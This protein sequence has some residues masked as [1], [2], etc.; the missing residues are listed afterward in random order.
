MSQ[1]IE[2]K[3]YY[4]SII[5]KCSKEPDPTTKLDE[6]EEQIKKIIDGTFP[7]EQEEYFIKEAFYSIINSLWKRNDF[8][9]K[10]C[11]RVNDFFK[12]SLDLICYKISEEDPNILSV[13]GRIFARP[14]HGFY[15]DYQT[16]TWECNLEDDY[17]SY[18]IK[19]FVKE[20]EK[21]ED[22]MKFH[23][24]KESMKK[25]S[26]LFLE[27]IEYFGQI[28]G[29]EKIIS[30]ILSE[31]YEISLK[32][33]DLLKPI[34]KISNQ[35]TEEFLQYLVPYL[36][37]IL[38][39]I[40]QLEFGKIRKLEKKSIMKIADLIF[41]TIRSYDNDLQSQIQEEFKLD[42]AEKFIHSTY[43]EMRVAG[44]TEIRGFILNLN[45]SPNKK[46]I[47]QIWI[48]K[49]KLLHWIK[50][51]KIVELIFGNHLHRETINRTDF[52][53]EFLA[54]NGEFT[55]EIFYLIWNASN[56][57]HQTTIEAIYNL[58]SRLSQYFPE[59]MYNFVFNKFIN[60]EKW[61][62]VS[63]SLLQNFAR[64]ALE[65]YNLEES[66]NKQIWIEPIKKFWG[67]ITD[68]KIEYQTK[69][70]LFED[71]KEL[72][73]QKICANEIKHSFL[74]QCITIITY[75]A[76][77]SSDNITISALIRSIQ[78]ENN[79]IQLVIEEMENFKNK[80]SKI[81]NETED[82]DNFIVEEGLIY[83]EE[84]SVRLEFLKFIIENTFQ[85][86]FSEKQ[87]N[88]LWDLFFKNSLS[89]KEKDY[90]LD[91]TTR[92][93][94]NDEMRQAFFQ[95]SELFSPENLTNKEFDFFKYFS[96]QYNYQKQTIKGINVIKVKTTE[97]DGVYGIKTIWNIILKTTNEDVATSAIYYLVEYQNLTKKLAATY[98]A[99]HRENFISHCMK[100]LQEDEVK[101]NSTKILRVLKV[102]VQ[103]IHLTESDIIPEFLPFTRHMFGIH[104][105]ATTLNISIKNDEKTKYQVQVSSNES[106]FSLRKKISKLLNK[107]FADFSIVSHPAINKL[108]NAKTLLEMGVLTNTNLE[109]VLREAPKPKDNVQ[110]DGQKFEDD[111]FVD[112]N[113]P[114]MSDSK[115]AKK[116]L[117]H[118]DQQDQYGYEDEDQEEAMK[119]RKEFIPTY[120]LSQYFE[121]LFKLLE[122]GNQIAQKVWYIILRMPTNK[123]YLESFLQM[124][125]S[126]NKEMKWNQIFHI[127][128]VYKLIY[129]L[130][131]VDRL[132]NPMSFE[133]KEGN[134]DGKQTQEAQKIQNWSENFIQTGGLKYLIESIPDVSLNKNATDKSSISQATSL[135]LKVI[136]E[137]IVD[138]Q[139]ITIKF[140]KDLEN[141]DVEKFLNVLFDLALNFSVSP[142]TNHFDS[143]HIVFYAINIICSGC[144]SQKRDEWVAAIRNR[145]NMLD[146][147][148]ATLLRTYNDNI[149]GNISFGIYH[150]CKLDCD[151]IKKEQ[152]EIQT[153]PIVKFFIDLLLKLL[154]QKP[155]E[156]QQEKTESSTSQKV[157]LTNS[158]FQLLS[159]LI[160]MNYSIRQE[161]NYDELIEKVVHLLQNYISSEQS[162]ETSSQPDEIL[163]GYLNLARVLLNKEKYRVQMEEKHN[164]IK[165]IF[166]KFLF[167]VPKPS[168]TKKK[169]RLSSK[170]QTDYSRKASFDLLNQI[171]KD[172]PDNFIRLFH[173]LK[174]LHKNVSS[175]STWSYETISSPKSP[176]GYLGLTNL[177]ATCYM[178]SLLQ[179]LYM[180]PEFRK[181]ML[182][183]NLEEYIENEEMKKRNKDEDKENKDG[184]ENE[185]ENENENKNKN[186]ENKDE[187]NK[188]NKDIEDIK[189]IVKKTLEENP[190]YHL[191]LIFARLS[192][193]DRQ[194]VNT[195]PFTKVFKQ[196]DGSPLNPYVQMDVYEFYNMLFDVM[197][198]NLRSVGKGTL[199]QQLFGGKF[200]NQIIAIESGNVSERLENFY[201]ISLDVLNQRNLEESLDL[202][203][204]G[205]MLVGDNQY[206]SEA[207]QKKVDAL[208]RV[209][210][211]ELPKVMVVNLKRFEYDLETMQ[212][213]KI[214][215]RF[216][217]PMTLNMRKYTREGIADDELA[218]LLKKKETEE[219]NE[220]EL[221]EKIET[222]QKII[223][224]AANKVYGYHLSGIIVH[225]GS[226][227]SGHYY[228]FIK[229][230]ESLSEDNSLRWLKF[231]DRN[232]SSFDI[233]KIDEECFG[234]DY[235]YHTKDSFGNQIERLYEKRHS[236]YMLFYER[237]DFAHQNPLENE[238]MLFQKSNIYDLVWKENV[239]HFYQKSL[240]DP[241]YFHFLS[242]LIQNQSAYSNKQVTLE[243]TQFVLQFIFQILLYSKSQHDTTEWL[244]FLNKQ[245]TEN[246]EISGYLLTE[247]SKKSNSWLKEMIWNAY[248]DAFVKGL[249]SIILTSIRKILPREK[250]EIESVI[251]IQEKFA[252]Q[253][254]ETADSEAVAKIW[255]EKKNQ[256]NYKK[257]PVIISFVDRFVSLLPLFNHK[258]MNITEYLVILKDIIDLDPCISKYLLSA[259]LITRLIDFYLGPES[260]LST[261]S[262]KSKFKTYSLSAQM[263][264]LIELISA[265]LL[266]SGS[267]ENVSFMDKFMLKKSSFFSI[268][269]NN[270]SNPVALGDIVN[271]LYSTEN[272]KNEICE[273]FDIIT[274]G[275][276]SSEFNL[277]SK[278][279]VLLGKIFEK[280]DEFLQF[281]LDYLMPN[282]FSVIENNFKFKKATAASI[283]LLH[284][285]SSKN[286][287]MIDWL[288]IH[289]DEWMYMWLVNH[290]KV[291]S[292]LHEL[293]EFLLSKIPDIIQTTYSTIQPSAKPKQNSI[294]PFDNDFFNLTGY[295]NLM[296]IC[297]RNTPLMNKSFQTHFQELWNLFS[298]IESY[299][300]F[301][302]LNK[303]QFLKFLEKCVIGNKD[304]IALIV[305]SA[306]YSQQIIESSIT[307][308]DDPI[309]VEYNQMMLPSLFNIIL[310]SC[311]SDPEFLAN[312][313]KSFQFKWA[314]KFLVFQ[315]DL[316]SKASDFI[317]Q[318][319]ALFADDSHV[320]KTYLNFVTQNP[321]CFIKSPK[322]VIMLVKIILNKE[323]GILHIL[324][325][326][327]N[328]K[329]LINI[330]SKFII[331]KIELISEY[332]LDYADL[333][334]PLQMIQT[335][336]EIIRDFLEEI[337]NQQERR[338]ELVAHLSEIWTK[339]SKLMK[340]L[341]PAIRFSESLE[342]KK[343]TRTCL[344]LMTRVFQMDSDEPSEV[345]S[346]VDGD[347]EKNEMPNFVT[348][349]EYDEFIQALITSGIK[350][351]IGLAVIDTFKIILSLIKQTISK[352]PN[353]HLKFVSI[354]FDVVSNPKLFE[355][356]NVQKVGDILLNKMEDYLALVFQNVELFQY[357]QVFNLANILFHLLFRI[358]E[359]SDL[360]TFFNKLVVQI[361]D[362]IETGIEEKNDLRVSC[363]L[364][365]FQ[366]D[367]LVS[368]KDNFDL[369][370]FFELLTSL[371]S[372]LKEEEEFKK[373]IIQQ[374]ESIQK[375]FQ[376]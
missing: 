83:I 177:G 36:Q 271:F 215:T 109:I 165:E 206:Y 228:S 195:R 176:T 311:K 92:I 213:Y 298:H 123:K 94:C 281:K 222:L 224:E 201:T 69:E 181:T 328:K 369:G 207:L 125:D 80:V 319:F 374:I 355:Q 4:F 31:N 30:H 78:E 33:F 360:K 51:K 166:E 12:R 45:P 368:N 64:G 108:N 182:S 259:N 84:V 282:L 316:Y 79:L 171:V 150:I 334:D 358:Y 142:E 262:S 46:N 275:I 254:E 27:N 212:R 148:R 68:L 326:F 234:G 376:K 332:E 63:I 66:E 110:N 295:F 29:F 345:I 194:Y 286:T 5:E 59:K 313:K 60:I 146:W 244:S 49:E 371:I 169:T 16:T 337:Y 159:N 72:F 322:N 129:Q 24:A 246:E 233:D 189:K 200:V 71:F 287:K 336:V 161:E 127:S 38:D 76:N 132:M 352:D 202:Y 188:E 346:L 130:Q 100:T 296:S 151:K 348:F 174:D 58:V 102:L 155:S 239:N 364:K 113:L 318:I 294:E 278:Y 88:I 99:N 126:Q 14:Y 163:I 250:S 273:I 302:D 291:D 363:S 237:D 98:G 249:V 225:L 21:I 116:Q 117:E 232:V 131:I 309:Y 144:S 118:F 186:K 308:N 227:E 134:R 256:K 325:S 293:F 301:C 290:S 173:Y 236:A 158:Y 196:W 331:E 47:K 105:S 204:K 289:K 168:I 106:I 190:F 240:L 9:Q 375:E 312:F 267:P 208:K 303:A 44:L 91:W 210:V 343:I 277:I 324:E 310:Y 81:K 15:E 279:F 120:I 276:D 48:T 314:M 185:N 238:Q 216:E 270:D 107:K 292:K 42:L 299:K 149:R 304:S 128:S 50:E 266:S 339:K 347:L 351:G 344:K 170:C 218:E 191:Q 214:N 95:K 28:H 357:E 193:S 26:G 226:S 97:I 350:N 20:S 272:Q 175:V 140:E 11:Q 187:D 199:L 362:Q 335:S 6:I 35:Y 139:N 122:H 219:D 143:S 327:Q 86:F 205:E 353:L 315:T 23:F 162:P 264:R 179:Q 342:D 22:E 235:V 65:K 268:S 61:D 145:K 230:K 361:Q 260:P 115:E 52:I 252:I 39:K 183:L 77:T 365:I 300:L 366:I 280:D 10:Y 53:L 192:E 285:I 356:E 121:D 323:S 152:K 269:I 87:T 160:E 138:P 211:K 333:Q 135:I 32:T 154:D 73:V 85:L 55:E 67:L 242:N 180:V 104:S 317:L 261:K 137:F 89:N 41:E 338:E 329:N 258:I 147:I 354:L 265:L 321:V 7:K 220:A 96:K 153:E 223:E 136:F 2:W 18:W 25:I 156:D 284:E 251:K 19:D 178:N 34:E 372:K 306:E 330:L 221:K 320:R 198:N 37:K 241:N 209:C 359:E 373:E 203:I 297:Y 114:D 243:F 341:I 305:N 141:I 103:L 75:P 119:I 197:E 8:D 133:N 70:E 172:S 62:V 74:N 231:E 307:L 263:T 112:V 93:F 17:Y 43:L 229:E 184:N 349:A 370:Y 283:R 3:T 367:A 101:N 82:L 90:F 255:N 167:D 248:N 13:L 247:L 288:F 124:L 340:S 245:F 274:K 217:F 157:V 164:L 57:Q 40:L 257:C 1:K 253:F 111:E 56:G 54:Q